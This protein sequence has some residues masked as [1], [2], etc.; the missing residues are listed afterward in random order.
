MPR[1]VINRRQIAIGGMNPLSVVKYFDIFEHRLLGLSA[2]LERLLVNQ[3]GFQGV[4]ETLRN[5][6]I[7]TVAFSTHALLNAVL[8]EQSPMA[9]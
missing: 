3:L 7:P 8:F 2:G 4:K 1:F 5:R 9:F 6:I